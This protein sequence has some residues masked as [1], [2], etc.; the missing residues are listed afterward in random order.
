MD[1]EIINNVLERAEKIA[2]QSQNAP[3]FEY[4]ANLSTAVKLLEKIGAHESMEWVNETQG[5]EL[6]AG[7]DALA[8][9]KKNNFSERCG[10]EHAAR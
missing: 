4:L 10:S 5:A 7:Y 1:F 2:E 8:E 3:I 9:L 6:A